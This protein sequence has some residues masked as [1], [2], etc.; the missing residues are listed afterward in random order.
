LTFAF[1]PAWLLAGA[2]AGSALYVHFRGRERLAFM[3]QIADHSTF[4]APYNTFVYLASRVP[5]RPVLDANAFPMPADRN[6][7]NVVPA[8]TVLTVSATDPTKHVAYTGSGTISGILAHSVEFQTSA[9][10]GAEPAPM[11]FHGCVFA[12]PAIVGFTTYAAAL[13]TAMPTCKFM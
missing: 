12:T 5:T 2:Y 4:L 10:D 11:F 13:V 7:R 3:R 8:G 6:A 9:T 1:A